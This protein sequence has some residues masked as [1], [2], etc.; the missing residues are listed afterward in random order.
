MPGVWVMQTHLQERAW[1]YRIC[2][3]KFLASERE[4]ERGREW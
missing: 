1:S 4:S 3:G 2:G